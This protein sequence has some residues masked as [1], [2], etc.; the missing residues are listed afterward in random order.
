MH[1]VQDKDINLNNQIL[2]G[3][4]LFVGS[5]SEMRQRPREFLKLSFFPVS[6]YSFSICLEILKRADKAETLEL[7]GPL[8]NH[9]FNMLLLN[10]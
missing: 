5:F 1:I 9:T 10:L 8:L 7:K 2:S 6:P 4:I 3:T